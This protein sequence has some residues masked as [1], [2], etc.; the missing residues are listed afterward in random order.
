MAGFA[1]RCAWLVLRADAHSCFFAPMRMAGFA[2]RCAQLFFRAD[3]HG[4]FCAPMRT[5]GFA[6]RCAW[7]ALRAPV[8]PDP[9]ADAVDAAC[10]CGIRSQALEN[11]AE[12]FGLDTGG[13]D[14]P[15][16][17]SD[18][19][20]YLQVWA[21]A[22][23]CLRVGAST[24]GGAWGSPTCLLRSLQSCASLQCLQCCLC[25]LGVVRIAS[26]L[27]VLLQ[28]CLFCFNVVRLLQSCSCC[29]NVWR[30]CAP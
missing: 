18:W 8:L 19:G 21:C 4:W 20:E 26:V 29:S 10:L 30:V 15:A 5:A 11:A 14:A 16:D 25:R 12:Q 2:R 13:G 3:A 9:A 27:F 17:P 28:C 22:H 1:R 7:P 24:W 6:R 23:A